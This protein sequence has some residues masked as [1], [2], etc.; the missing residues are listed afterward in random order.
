ME[1]KRSY[2]CPEA[3]EKM[4]ISAFF[5][6]GFAG[7]ASPL[8]LEALVKSLQYRLHINMCHLKCLVA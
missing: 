7:L 8:I 4:L 6:A 1:R 5:F 3:T 2:K